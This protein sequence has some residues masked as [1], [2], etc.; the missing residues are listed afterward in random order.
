LRT[1]EDDDS[2][3][4]LKTPASPDFALTDDLVADWRPGD[5]W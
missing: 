1:P 3:M 4:V 2:I 5:V